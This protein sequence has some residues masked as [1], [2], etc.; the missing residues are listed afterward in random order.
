[1]ARI[2]KADVNRALETAA[3]TLIKIGGS[4]G[5]ISRAEV[6]SALATDRVPRQQAALVDIFFK[7]IDNRD[8]R[9]GAQVTPADVKRAVE[10]AKKSMI[11]KYDLDSNGLSKDE[12]AKMS[13]TGKRAVDLAKALKGAAP[14]PDVEAPGA[15]PGPVNRHALDSAI[16]DIQTEWGDANI[17]DGHASL[18][19]TIVTRNAV[20]TAERDLAAMLGDD[21]DKFVSPR[22]AEGPRALTTADLGKIARAVNDDGLQYAN[23]DAVADFRKQLEGIVKQLGGPAGLEVGVVRQQVQVFGISDTDKFPAQV[24]TIR[25]PVTNDAVSI[26]VRKGSL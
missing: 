21:F 26:A 17:M 10:Y 22:I 4:D 5:R 20:A 19:A 18:E 23:S 16:E 1:M 24:W 14:T 12:I 3:K 7:F 25:N 13:L 6:K 15:G 8:F 9:T 11:A 2:A